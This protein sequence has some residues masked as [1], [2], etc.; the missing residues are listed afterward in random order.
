MF[1]WDGFSVIV[2]RQKNSGV[3]L[4]EEEV[5]VF[6]SHSIDFVHL[7]WIITLIGSH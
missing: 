2:I 5:S 1:L 6:L 7:K 4:K 3:P